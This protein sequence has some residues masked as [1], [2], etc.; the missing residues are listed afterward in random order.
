MLTDIYN[1]NKQ[2]LDL[3]NGNTVTPDVVREGKVKKE[4]AAKAPS[5]LT[6]FESNLPTVISTGS[7][8]AYDRE[9]AK[10]VEFRDQYATTA[11]QV[12]LANEKIAGVEFAKALNFD[13]TSLITISGGFENMVKSL[14]ASAGGMKSSLDSMKTNLIDIS[15]VLSQ[16]VTDLAV[17][18]IAS[19]GEAIGGL[20]AGT[21]NIGD[22][23]S[24]ML[25]MI[26]GFM[27][28]LGRQLIALGI[29]KIAFEKIAISGV[30][31]VIAGTALVALAAIFKGTLNKGP[32][33]Q[34]FADGGIV[35]G[36]SF[37]GDKILA[38][39]NSGELVLNNKQQKAVFAG[40]SSAGGGVDV[41]II[42][43][44][45]L[46]GSDF[47]IMFERAQSRKNRIGK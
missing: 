36:S 32:K 40:M 14:E 11:N 17:N 27:S 10:L 3:L 39:V 24:G 47:L 42:P 31:A 37:Y 7:I 44:I 5:N 19:F 26:A 4:K 23:I 38:R 16:T 13:P 2:N 29:A 28:D 43:N 30:G 46:V 45:K 20:V 12:Q 1:K 18:V 21:A 15:A 9:I 22:V 8:E 35:G 25:G 41:S 6:S 33:M 34:A